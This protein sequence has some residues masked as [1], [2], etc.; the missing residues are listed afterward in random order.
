M[1]FTPAPLQSATT[2]EFKVDG[3]IVPELARDLTLI[4]IDEDVSGMRRMLANFIAIGPRPN[5]RDGQLNWLDGRVLDFGKAI[6]VSMGPSDARAEVFNGKV[7][8]LE[9][10][11]DQGR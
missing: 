10:A 7:S 8:A 6:I 3:A 2:P 4:Q 11:M 5:E 1:T 9:L